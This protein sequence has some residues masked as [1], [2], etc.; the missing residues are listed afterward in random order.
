MDD[1]PAPALRDGLQAVGHVGEAVI[2]ARD[3]VEPPGL[4][5]A[6]VEEP[7]VPGRHRFLIEFAH[8]PR[9][10]GR[11]ALALDAAL[12]RLNEDYQAHR[13]GDLTLLAPEVCA[14]PR[15]GFTGWMRAHGK[16]GGQHKVPR[17]DNSGE[18]TAALSRWF[19]RA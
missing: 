13:S 17:M 18:L 5:R 16:L 10:A 6:P 2:G 15:G 1:E 8:P 7:A 14:V 19:E 3:H 4:A 9:D 12:G 11:F